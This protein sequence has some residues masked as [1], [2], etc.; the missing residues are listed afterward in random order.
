MSKLST[1][2]SIHSDGFALQTMEEQDEQIAELER[3]ADG[4]QQELVD[5]SK[6]LE[7]QA[8]SMQKV[9]CTFLSNL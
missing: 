1:A 3:I 5:V 6:S 8:S 4:K 2:N 9:C 7:Q